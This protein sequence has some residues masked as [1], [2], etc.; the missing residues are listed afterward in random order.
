MEYQKKCELCGKEFV[1]Q[2][3]EG[4]F[5]STNCRVTANRNVTPKPTKSADIIPDVTP[6][7]TNTIAWQRV[8]NGEESG[9]DIGYGKDDYTRE[10]VE[11]RLNHGDTFVP[12][13][14]VIGFKSKKHFLNGKTEHHHPL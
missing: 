11:D 4:K 2:R 7:P 8:M 10:M 5:C 13:W 12:N 9:V 1:S 6:K 3:P 14:Y